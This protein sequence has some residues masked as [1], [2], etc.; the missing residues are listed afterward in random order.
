M[1]RIHIVGVSPRSGTTLLAECMVAC[2]A[3]DAFES[4]E[5]PLARHRRGAKVYLTKNPGDIW[6]VRPRLLVDRHLHVIALLRDPRDV[7]VSRHAIDPNRYWTPLRLWTARVRPLRR[8]LRHERFVL[9]R[10]E[11][12]ARNP[13]GVQDLLRR[14]LPFLAATGRFSEF[15]TRAAPSEEALK[16]LGGVRPIGANRIGAWRQHLPRVAGQLACHGPITRELIEFGYEPDDRWL[17]QLG[18]VELDLSPSYWPD[19]ER[20][21]WKARLRRVKRAYSE[22]ATM[23]AARLFGVPLA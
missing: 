22:A 19:T 15:Q 7:I 2:F 17:E 14:K 3:I 20:A 12:L 16:A 21:P 11:D 5:A 13:D 4:H 8:L 9:V 18:G 10:Y 1:E 23:G 6:I